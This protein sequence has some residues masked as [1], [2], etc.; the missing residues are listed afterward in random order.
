MRTWGPHLAVATQRGGYRCIQCARQATSSAA[1][2]AMAKLKCT[3]RP[4][5]SP[6]RMGAVA[7]EPWNQA[8]VARRAGAGGGGHDAVLYAHSE[9]DGRHLCLACGRHTVRWRDFAAK[10]LP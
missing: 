9:S 7:W 1:K 3:D 10:A 2:R 5:L 6:W 4:G 8:I